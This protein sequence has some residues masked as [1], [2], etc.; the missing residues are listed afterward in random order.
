MQGTG[1]HWRGELGRP[2][3][4]GWVCRA[5][6][7]R[8]GGRAWGARAGAG[9]GWGVGAGARARRRTLGR[10]VGGQQARG[11]RSR[12]EDTTWM[13]GGV[14]KGR[15]GR[16]VGRPLCVW[17]ARLGQVGCLGA[18]DSVFWPGLTQYFS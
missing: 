7:E 6:A 5:R 13:H 4:R 11:A 3:A 9:R 14:R 18:P 12:R 16:P 2:W 1:R 15:A 17:C 8:A 10:R